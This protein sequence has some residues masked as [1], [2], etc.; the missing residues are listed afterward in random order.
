[1]WIKKDRPFVTHSQAEIVLAII[2]EPTSMNKHRIKY[3]L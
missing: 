2:F 3:M 1:V